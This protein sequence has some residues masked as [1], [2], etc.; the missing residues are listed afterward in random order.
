VH[1]AGLMDPDRGSLDGTEPV[2]APYDG[3]IAACPARIDCDGHMMNWRLVLIADLGVAIGLAIFMSVFIGSAVSTLFGSTV[4]LVFGAIA[5]ILTFFGGARIAFGIAHGLRDLPPTPRSDPQNADPADGRGGPPAMRSA[6]PRWLYAVLVVVGLATVFAGLTDTSGPQCG[7][8]GLWKCLPGVIFAGRA[9]SIGVGTAFV[10]MGILHLVAGR[11]PLATAVALL[12]GAIDLAV[13]GW[14]GYAL[15]TGVIP[16]IDPFS[17]AWPLVVMVS[18]TGFGVGF[19]AAAL[20]EPV[21]DRF[22][23]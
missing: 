21:M 2:A 1:F 20:S 16:L 4:G 11:R 22:R 19:F 18:S 14:I 8:P 9:L 17:A 3:A 5:G 6:N 23:Q 15:A 10:G 12:A 7:V 13:G